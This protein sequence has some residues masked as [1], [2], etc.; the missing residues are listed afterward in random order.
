MATL[1]T[2]GTG[3]VASNVV[4]TLA[5]WGHEVI[6]LDITPPDALVQR[7]VEPWKD[8]ITWVTGDITDR[9]TLEQLAGNYNVRKIVHL[10]VATPPDE[11]RERESTLR[12]IDIN[13]GGTANLLDLARQF[14][15]ERFVYTSS[16]GGIYGWKYRE[17]IPHPAMSST[18]EILSEDNPANPLTL[19][20]VTKYS[21]ELLVQQYNELH[22]LDTAI[23]RIAGPYGPMERV[24]GCAITS[25][26]VK[27]IISWTDQSL[28]NAHRTIP[29]QASALWY[30]RFRRAN[31]G[32]ND[33]PP[34][35]GVL[36]LNPRRAGVAQPGRAPA[37]QAGRHE[38][39]SRSPL[40]LT[41]RR[42]GARRGCDG[43]P[44]R[45]EPNN[46]GGVPNT[47]ERTADGHE[48]ASAFQRVRSGDASR[49][50]AR[51]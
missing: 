14:S 31:C 10:A 15:M 42:Q 8:H 20:G 40:H 39:E 33:V 22:G 3:F 27:P 16:S 26:G 29:I 18:D 37:F 2:G 38:F 48:R 7:Y 46:P 49:R 23:A 28:E 12:I 25:R 1:V 44:Y 50:T 4:R 24:T 5:E 6:S 21:S 32:Y 34:P 43:F 41:C 13:L 30:E 19:Y 45:R 47:S 11:E 35:T 51:A 9:A 17:W 36:Q